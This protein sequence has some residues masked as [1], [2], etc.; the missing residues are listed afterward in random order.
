MN[1]RASQLR[2][3][4]FDLDGLM[5]NT[6][7]LYQEVGGTILAR[8]GKKICSD[9]LDQMMG[10][11]SNVAL[12]VMIEWHQLDATP[13]QLEIESAEIFVD[14]L[15]ARL[16]PMPGLLELLAAL[17]AAGIPKAIATSSGR[18]FV[19][20]TLALFQLQPRFSFVLTA[21]NIEHGKPAPDVYL[22]A[23]ERHSVQPS[24]MM[25]LEDSQIGCQAAVAAG[26]YAVAVPHGQS[27]THKFPGVQFEANTLADSRIYTA[28][29]IEQSDSASGQAVS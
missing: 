2:A 9:L 16:A 22:L 25:V 11:K 5:F 17:E 7:E 4:T 3:V 29:G 14:L 18:A 13:E 6:E 23:A 10:R 26:A 24:E 20:Q 28:L 27:S 1:Q 15:P 12:A 19:E 21:E 8:R